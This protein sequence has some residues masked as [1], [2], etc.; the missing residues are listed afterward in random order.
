MPFHNLE[1]FRNSN[2][3]YTNTHILR[4]QFL[5]LSNSLTFN[6]STVA[7]LLSYVVYRLLNHKRSQESHNILAQMIHTRI[8]RLLKINIGLCSVCGINLMSYKKWVSL[9]HLFCSFVLSLFYFSFSFSYPITHS[10]TAI[11]FAI[12]VGNKWMCGF[13]FFRKLH[14]WIC[15]CF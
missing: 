10:L 8:L 9:I 12:V 7:L 14:K 11:L 1:Y 13:F 4:I 2:I 15:H 3:F 5:S 6:I